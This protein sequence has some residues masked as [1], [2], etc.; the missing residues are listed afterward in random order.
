MLH[1]KRTKLLQV[2]K[3]GP[4]FLLSKNFFQ[5]RNANLKRV[6]YYDVTNPFDTHLRKVINACPAKFDVF[7][8]NSFGTAKTERQ[9][10]LHFIA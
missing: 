8:P 2:G 9:T 4:G 10:K 1:T 3:L 7:T 5:S 6:F